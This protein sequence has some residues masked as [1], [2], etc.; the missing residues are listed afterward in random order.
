[1]CVYRIYYSVKKSYESTKHQIEN[2][3]DCLV[4]RYN[5]LKE[6]ADYAPLNKASK[7]C[8]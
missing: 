2:E 5:S 4:N 1:M 8:M 6:Y 3:I 7:K